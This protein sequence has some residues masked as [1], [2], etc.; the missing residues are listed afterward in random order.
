M[1]IALLDSILCRIHAKITLIKHPSNL[2]SHSHNKSNLIFEDLPEK[3]KQTKVPNAAT[4]ISSWHSEGKDAFDSFNSQTEQTPFIWRILNWITMTQCC[5]CF[6]ASLKS[7]ESQPARV[8][9]RNS[10]HSICSFIHHTRGWKYNINDEYFG[11]RRPYS[12][13][14]HSELFGWY[15]LLHWNTANACKSF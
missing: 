11:I 8:T 2:K 1:T 5:S 9:N 6:R 12:I 15:V 7:F 14:K 3:N 4:D 10:L 13:D